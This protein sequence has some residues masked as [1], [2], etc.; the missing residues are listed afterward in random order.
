M[1]Q[2]LKGLLVLALKGIKFI[3]LA[4]RAQLPHAKSK[5]SAK[6]KP[7]CAKN[8]RLQV[9]HVAFFLGLLKGKIGVLG[10]KACTV[11]VRTSKLSYF[12]INNFKNKKVCIPDVE[13]GPVCGHGCHKCEACWAQLVTLRKLLL[14]LALYQMARRSEVCSSVVQS[15]IGG[16]HFFELFYKLYI[17]IY[18]FIYI[19][20]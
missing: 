16:L 3:L 17:Y 15:T 8:F 13:G 10:L 19:Y 18:I 6:I 12:L 9:V 4:K 2:Y 14:T 5:K 7:S 1:L 11:I 20:I